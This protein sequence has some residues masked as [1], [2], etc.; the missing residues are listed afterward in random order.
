[1][2]WRSGIRGGSGVRSGWGGEGEWCVVCGMWHGVV[3]VCG[4]V[5]VVWAGVRTRIGLWRVDFDLGWDDRAYSCS[6]LQHAAAY[7]CST[8]LQYTGS[9]VMG[10]KAYIVSA[11][12]FIQ[13][14]ASGTQ[15]PETGVEMKETHANQRRAHLRRVGEPA[16]L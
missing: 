11:R 7:S 1:M 8:Q 13:Q 12:E 6:M 9:C 4:M 2:P 10:A 16:P 5:C 15:G 14:L 3:F